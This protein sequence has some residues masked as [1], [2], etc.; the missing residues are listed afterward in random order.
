MRTIR[1][2]EL[3]MRTLLTHTALAGCLLWVALAT[4]LPA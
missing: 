4:N 3:D 2:T 1:N